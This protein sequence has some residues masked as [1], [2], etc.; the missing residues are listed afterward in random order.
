MQYSITDIQRFVQR[1]YG[2]ARL[3]VT[4]FG[5]PVLFD[6][7]LDPATSLTYT[8]SINIQANADFVLTDVAYKVIETQDVENK[9]VCSASIIFRESGSKEPFTDTPVALENYAFNG[10]AQRPLDYPRFLAGASNI[11]CTLILR[12]VAEQTFPDGIEV[13]LNGFLVRVFN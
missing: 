11:E 3:L 5:Y 7:N 2:T 6:A 8:R 1:F 4:P 12:N 10:I 13:M 9:M